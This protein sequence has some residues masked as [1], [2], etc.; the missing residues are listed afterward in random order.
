MWLTGMKK[1]IFRVNN[2]F[3]SGHFFDP[4]CVKKDQKRAGTK[5]FLVSKNQFF[6]A[7]QPCKGIFEICIVFSNFGQELQMAHS[8]PILRI[9]V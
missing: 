9:D 4:S 7:H 8:I 1:V 6:E 5:N 3:G 2:F